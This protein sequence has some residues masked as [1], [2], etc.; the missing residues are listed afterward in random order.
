[1]AH[2]GFLFDLDGT[3]V[4]SLA[5]VEQ[6]WVAWGA[7]RGL[8]ADTLLA[9]IHGKPAMASLRHFMAGCSEEAI[10]QQFLALEETEAA[11]VEGI[12]AL[13]GALALLNS[14]DAQGI[15]W[16]IV[17]SGSVPVARARHRAAAL[18]EPAIWVT[19]GDITCGKPHPEPYLLGATRLQLPPEACVVVEDAAAGIA[20]ALDAGCYVAGVNVPAEAAR[21]GELP[22]L[23]N[24]LAQLTVRRRPDGSVALTVAP[25]R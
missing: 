17:T 18:P 6:A 12:V 2:R 4:D 22:L 15:P 5:M 25:P 14:L 7:R 10:Q 9:F 8:E 24:S 20:S 16:G 11:A 23:L 3:L 13:P 21:R 19:A 1:M